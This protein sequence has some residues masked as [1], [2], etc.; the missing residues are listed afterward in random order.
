MNLCRPDIFHEKVHD[1]FSKKVSRQVN[2]L[3]ATVGNK[4]LLLCMNSSWIR[5]FGL[6]CI[7]Y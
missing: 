2:Q 1:V 7:S 6:L 3:K 5:W 4:Y